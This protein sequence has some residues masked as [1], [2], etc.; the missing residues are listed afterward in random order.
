MISE[1]RLK[2]FCSKTLQIINNVMKLLFLVQYPTYLKHKSMQWKQQKLS[3]VY[4]PTKIKY[5]TIKTRNITNLCAGHNFFFSG[6]FIEYVSVDITYVFWCES[7]Y[8]LIVLIYILHIFRSESAFL[9]H[10]R[11]HTTYIFW[12]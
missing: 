1:K 6:S 5:H 9:K 12:C 11:I 2:I 8:L 10:I 7:V 3:L 4:K